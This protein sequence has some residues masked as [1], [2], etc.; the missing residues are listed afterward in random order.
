VIRRSIAAL[1]ALVAFALISS[2]A[3][4]RTVECQHPLSTGM[5]AFNLKDVSPATA[6]R[7][8]IA[9]SKW[10]TQWYVC[11]GAG[12]DSV[13]TP[14]IK[15]HRFDGWTLSVPKRSA[16]LMSRG[17]GSFQVEGTDFPINCS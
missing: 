6:C 7:L 13:G 9:L 3:A 8:V 11:T 4:A 15:V 14:V 16:L 1:V 2:P 17:K 5:E 10:K 12:S